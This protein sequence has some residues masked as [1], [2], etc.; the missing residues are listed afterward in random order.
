MN[1]PENV[2][3][4]LGPKKSHG[5]DIVSA[6]SQGNSENPLSEKA[7]AAFR[8]VQLMKTRSH[9]PE[10][11]HP[12]RTIHDSRVQAVMSRY[13]EKLSVFP[14]FHSI[15][16]GDREEES[17][18]GQS[19]LP[20]FGDEAEL[21]GNMYGSVSLKDTS[22]APPLP[23]R[24]KG[25]ENLKLQTLP[26]QLDF[27]EQTTCSA[28]I[29]EALLIV[30]GENAKPFSVDGASSFSRQFSMH[31]TATTVET[32]EVLDSLSSED[33][34]EF[35]AAGPFFAVR[36]RIRYIP[37]EIDLISSVLSFT[38]SLGVFS[39]PVTGVGIANEF[40]VQPLVGLK[41]PVNIHINPPVRVY[42]PHRLPMQIY[43]AYS[44]QKFLSIK[45]P[46]KLKTDASHSH[47]LEGTVTEDGALYLD[48][49]DDHSSWLVR[50]GT[51]QE[52]LRLS[53]Q[54]SSPGVYTAHVVIKTKLVGTPSNEKAAGS[55]IIIPVHVIVLQGGMTAT[56]DTVSLPSMT[57]PGDQISFRFRL[58]HWGA[59]PLSILGAYLTKPD[60][61]MVADYADK[62]RLGEKRL[63]PKPFPKS[64]ANL[65]FERG[66]VILPGETVTPIEIVASAKSEGDFVGKIIVLTNDTNPALARLEIP[67]SC[68]IHYGSVKSTEP[69][70]LHIPSS[71]NEGG[72]SSSS[73]NVDH[74]T[75]T[76][77]CLPS[78][79]G[80]RKSLRLHNNFK[81]PVQIYSV[82]SENDDLFVDDKDIA[83]TVVDAGST[84]ANALDLVYAAPLPLSETRQ[85]SLSINTS[86]G[87]QYSQFHVFHGRLSI[88]IG[89]I[90]KRGLE[91]E[92]S[93]ALG[94]ATVRLPMG[95][96]TDG[97]I[98]FAL[99]EVSNPNPIPI[100]V[101]RLHSKF[102][103]LD[104]ALLSDMSDFLLPDSWKMLRKIGASTIALLA[105]SVSKNI[106]ELD[107]NAMRQKLE[108]SDTSWWDILRNFLVARCSE[109]R[110]E[111]LSWTC[112]LSGEKSGADHFDQQEDDIHGDWRP[113]VIMERLLQVSAITDDISL[114]NVKDGLNFTH[115]ITADDGDNG[116]GRNQL[117][118]FS[119]KQF[120]V[121][122]RNPEL[123]RGSNETVALQLSTFL[124][125]DV[126]F[127]LELE[128]LEGNAALDMLGANDIVYVEGGQTISI[129]TQT[130][131]LFTSDMGTGAELPL[132][133]SS[134]IAH[135]LYPLVATTTD[136]SRR[137]EV[138]L[139][140][141]FD[142]KIAS[143]VPPYAELFE[144]AHVQILPMRFCDPKRRRTANKNT[145]CGLYINASLVDESM[146]A[147]FASE[148][149][150][151]QFV[152]REAAWKSLS[153]HGRMLSSLRSEIQVSF[154]VTDSEPLIIEAL[155]QEPKI[156]TEP[157][158]EGLID[159]GVVQVGSTSQATYIEVNNPTNAPMWAE[160]VGGIDVVPLPPTVGGSD[161]TQTCPESLKKRKIGIGYACEVLHPHHWSTALPLLL[162]TPM[163]G[164]FKYARRGKITSVG[165]CRPVIKTFRAHLDKMKPFMTTSAQVKHLTNEFQAFN[166]AV[167]F[168]ELALE[169]ASAT[170]DQMAPK[171]E[172]AWHFLRT[173]GKLLIGGL[174]KFPEARRAE[175]IAPGAS[176]ELGPIFFTPTAALQYAST[177]YVRNNLT[178]VAKVDVRGRGGAGVLSILAG[179]SMLR[180]LRAVAE[181]RAST[182]D[183]GDGEQMAQVER[184]EGKSIYVNGE[185][186]AYNVSEYED[187]ISQGLPFDFLFA[188]ANFGDAPMIVSKLE[189]DVASSRENIEFE[190]TNYSQVTSSLPWEL[191][192]GAFHIFNVNY[193]PTCTVA[194][195][196][197]EIVA[198]ASSS[199]TPA[200]AGMG[201]KF[202]DEG[203]FLFQPLLSDRVLD[204]CARLRVAQVYGNGI[205]SSSF[206][207]LGYLATAIFLSMFIFMTLLMRYDFGSQKQGAVV[208]RLLEQPLH[209]L[210]SMTPQLSENIV[211]G[212]A[213]DRASALKKPEETHGMAQRHHGVE[214]ARAEKQSRENKIENFSDAGKADDGSSEVATFEGKEAVKEQDK[215]PSQALFVRKRPTI[216]SEEMAAAQHDSQPATEKQSPVV[217]KKV[218]AKLKQREFQGVKRDGKLHDEKHAEK[219]E[220]LRARNIDGGDDDE[221]EEEEEEE[222]EQAA[223][224]KKTEREASTSSSVSE[225]V[226]NNDNSRVKEM[227]DLIERQKI[228][229]QQLQEK[230]AAAE[231]PK[232]G[233]GESHAA[234][235]KRL[236][237]AHPESIGRDAMINQG[238]GSAALHRDES[239]IFGLQNNDVPVSDSLVNNSEIGSSPWQAQESPLLAAAFA[240]SA[241]QRPSFGSDDDPH[242]SISSN[243]DTAFPSSQRSDVGRW[244][245]PSTT[246]PTAG[247][248][249]MMNMDLPSAQ[250]LPP[251]AS[252]PGGSFNSNDMFADFPPSRPRQG[253]PAYDGS[254]AGQS[255][256]TTS[257]GEKATPSSPLMASSSGW[258]VDD[259]YSSPPP[260]LSNNEFDTWGSPSTLPSH[261]PELNQVRMSSL[262]FPRSAIMGVQHP[263]DVHH[264][265]MQTNTAH[266][267]P[268]SLGFD[269]ETGAAPS[270][271]VSTP[272][273]KE[274]R[275]RERFARLQHWDGN[276]DS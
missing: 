176:L 231:N 77:K 16:D 186:V 101:T 89:G 94:S 248:L 36:V 60:Q 185:E 37:H 169:D 154:D 262:A 164:P 219:E 247:S 193:K 192:P 85:F 216:S 19:E 9:V 88:T 165:S 50:P 180:K 236:P 215:A 162:D 254:Y 124:D 201:K 261:S 213:G 252:D 218:T 269:S 126:K 244:D 259:M 96:A 129:P 177:I 147:N 113:R 189:I 17:L 127:I 52:V 184:I 206:R 255:L 72:E 83:N 275:M 58:H 249:G 179:S 31:G 103:G 116:T 152:R 41:I 117:K 95:A 107:V 91:N 92:T 134:T 35:V 204:G 90:S 67:Y 224:E 43:E 25:L 125:Q 145:W 23:L 144:V 26:K 160:L 74:T 271:G 136:P 59:L 210:G 194:A 208:A 256:Q 93:T 28:S 209:M 222:E 153:P 133:I 76:L 205:A 45:P 241:Q 207:F 227:E 199:S 44:S 78:E 240:P 243:M 237:K 12:L 214:Q 109:E 257:I 1:I 175:L 14:D 105:G 38:T 5:L 226:T 198:R 73:C 191:K 272:K 270:A 48:H 13:I 223:E 203:T 21:D 173:A 268:R 53:F 161:N 118:P 260:N 228:K 242:A 42:N 70:A 188:V 114:R 246:V 122:L 171:L 167:I 22:F 71:Y 168:L 156:V 130:V 190:I 197:I 131:H 63:A 178:G 65:N 111:E 33:S 250:M 276:E 146:N 61:E 159:F 98:K 108:G 157:S 49:E 141:E 143:G 120:I 18:E 232:S 182:G 3:R 132:F 234:G 212:R 142:S 172:T 170:V 69:P 15:K 100:V 217:G 4:A 253:L 150:M 166:D 110:P 40:K 137:V 187:V 151:E 46:A 183:M 62:V 174:P 119:T 112:S 220:A 64:Q 148:L 56:P 75:L 128:N 238:L 8:L 274:E 30:Q 225:S 47:V 245:W 97:K 115:I 86:L 6:G 135:D 155:L 251:I 66:Y 104:F 140:E 11:R 27:G 24:E 273:S 106:S 55:E 7:A 32:S 200:D 265:G 20:R 68:R 139:G 263:N 87:M 82:T 149:E 230:L 121:R 233:D 211:S 181:A 196:S 81:I 229:M 10:Y 195:S 235:P 163:T 202:S 102:Q 266:S 80:R 34:S 29:M 239:G 84:W 2:L 258:R 267:A 221:E 51:T 39:L 138:I 57:Q 79:E 264:S 158:E 123:L 54:T 99:L